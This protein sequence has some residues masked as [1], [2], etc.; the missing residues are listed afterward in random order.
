ME[1]HWG[2]KDDHTRIKYIKFTT[3]KGNTIEGGNPNKRMKGVATAGAPMGYQL[4]G[5][6]GRSGG[7]LDSVG[8][9]WTSIEPVE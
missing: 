3:S 1:A 9:S 6:F 4:G 7:E 5:F 8:A 2:E